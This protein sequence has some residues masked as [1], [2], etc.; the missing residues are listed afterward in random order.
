MEASPTYIPP[1]IRDY[2]TLEELTKDISL[3]SPHGIG[4]RI[5]AVTGPIGGG[6]GGGGNIQPAHTQGG[7]GD[8]GDLNSGGGGGGGGGAPVGATSPGSAGGGAGSGGGGAGGGGAGGGHGQL[9][10]TGFPAAFAGAVGGVMAG[11]G[12]YLRKVLRPG[13]KTH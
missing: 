12:A 2:G 11:T 7:A 13:P 6:G 1:Q 8:V 4:G 9:P 5:A 10:F 3:L